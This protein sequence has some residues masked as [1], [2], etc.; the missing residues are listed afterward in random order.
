[1]NAI[2]KSMAVVNAATSE[3][4][5][6]D[7]ARQIARAFGPEIELYSVYPA[8][9]SVGR[10]FIGDRLREAAREHLKEEHERTLNTLAAPL[11]KEGHLVTIHAEYAS[12]VHEQLVCRIQEIDCDLLIPG[13]EYS[14]RLRRC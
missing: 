12:P 14:Q 7:R 3:Q 1:M 2:K 13:S 8:S 11:R 10:Q 4:S 5:A 9:P 6:I